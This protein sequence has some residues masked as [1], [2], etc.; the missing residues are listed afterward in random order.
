M[1]RKADDRF[2]AVT[3]DNEYPQQSIADHE[4]LMSFQ[5]DEEAAF[6]REWWDDVGARQFGRWMDERPVEEQ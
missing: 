4:V 5:H 3:F 2:T 6:F 1:A